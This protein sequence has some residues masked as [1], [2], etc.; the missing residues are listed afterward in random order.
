MNTHNDI[1][2]RLRRCWS[3]DTW[4]DPD[5]W[6]QANP[7]WGQCAVTACLVQDIRWGRHPLDDGNLS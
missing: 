2:D 5:H 4:S 7:A 3:A 6:E 1:Y